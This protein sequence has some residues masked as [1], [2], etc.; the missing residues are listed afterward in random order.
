MKTIPGLML[1]LLTGLYLLLS[2]IQ[3]VAG[4]HES[5]SQPHKAASGYGIGDKVADFRLKNI[6]GKMVSLKDFE[7]AKGFVI[8][9]VSNHC[10]FSK[11]YEDRI[12]SIDRKYAAQGFPVI[13]INPNDPEAYEEDS[14]ANMQARARERGYTYPYLNDNTQAVTRLFGATRTPQAFVLKKENGHLVVQ[15]I[16]AIDDNSQE[17]AL[18]TRHY[19]SDA[20]NNLLLGKPV[21]TTTTKPIGCAIK[22]KS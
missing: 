13:A 8:I 3:T 21:V 1:T 6:D 18:V 16:G 14:F 5:A 4:A 15:Y 10:P 11:S 9:F 20:V 12:N 17:P 2:N 7:S 19:V 22:W